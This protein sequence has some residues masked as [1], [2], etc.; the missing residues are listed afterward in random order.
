MPI[1]DIPGAD[2]LETRKSN[3]LGSWPLRSDDNRVEPVCT[4]GFAVPFRLKPGEAIFT[5]GS[6]FAR[7]IETELAR[8][9]HDLPTRQVLRDPSFETV[10]A[11]SLNNFGTP[12][13]YNEFAWAFDEVPFALEDHICELRPGRWIDL[14]LPA[15][16]RPAPFDEV[17][18]RR[19]AL[20]AV[21][22]KVSDCRVVIVTLGYV[23]V[24]YD[25]RTGTYLNTTPWPSLLRA[26]PDRFRLHVLSFEETW[27]F[28]NKTIALLGKH[29][30]ADQQILLTVS[31]IPLRNT[32]RAQ[33]VILANTYSKSVL[34]AVAETACAEF[35]NTAYYPSYESITL[36]S[37]TLAWRDDQMHANAHVIALNIDRM[38]QAYT[39]D[40][41][42]FEAGDVPV[43]GGLSKALSA[44]RVLATAPYDGEPTA[45]ETALATFPESVDLL[46]F[47]ARFHSGQGRTEKALSLIETLSPEER[48]RRDIRLVQAMAYMTAGQFLQAHD[49][50]TAII[51]D[52]TAAD[53]ET[54]R[55][56]LVA[57]DAT[58]D[59][60]RLLSALSRIF[61][62]HPASVAPSH[63]RVARWY[64]R[65]GR[66]T[67]AQAHLDTADALDPDLPSL[68]I[69]QAELFIITGKRQEAR[70]LLDASDPLTL[71]DKRRAA[72]LYTQLLGLN[73]KAEGFTSSKKDEDD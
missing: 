44:A 18:R 13:I 42:P 48:C 47:A 31:P 64:L 54:R 3:D 35:P 6:C 46:L 60:D 20:R 39:D 66:L 1:Y 58:D 56:L 71:T 8:R 49:V 59:E 51:D 52:G 55:R 28:L 65:H 62:H 70:D 17:C 10:Q 11:E 34:R 29:S 2:A 53:L 33:D 24:W 63:V 41:A 69:A 22:R 45:F 14:H 27:D 43:D 37:R 36:T 26:E 30:R 50:Y 12:S 16:V 5:V 19:D 40:D 68:R 4:P 23:E 9:G 7:N 61:T 32:Y 21:Y 25:C 57:A 67:N 38:I 15:A 73:S 72:R